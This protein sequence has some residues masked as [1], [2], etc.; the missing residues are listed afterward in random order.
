M[1]F[2][3]PLTMEETKQVEFYILTRF[4]DFCKQHSLTYYLAYGTL[5]GAVRHGGFIPWD[6]DIDIQIPREDYEK[7]LEIYPKGESLRLIA[8]TDPDAEHT[9]AKLVDEDTVKVEG[10]HKYKS[11]ADYRGVD[12]D[13]FPIDGQPEDDGEYSRWFGRLRR[14]YRKIWMR[15]CEL[16]PDLK[17]SF[18]LA[19]MCFK[20]AKIFMP[21]RKRLLAKAAALH[22]KYPYGES[23]HVGCIESYF[24]GIGNRNLKSDYEDVVLLDFEDRKF[25]APVGYHDILTNMYGDYMKLPPEDK[26]VTHHTNVT[27]RKVKENEEI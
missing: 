26:R 21:S 9:F 25:P 11:D 13:I 3:K 23:K 14:V 8:P 17:L 20:I 2:G 27:Y 10:A 5:L 1:K 19:I 12:I 4:D 6:D 15:E 16:T 7:L 24:N 18:K 22:A